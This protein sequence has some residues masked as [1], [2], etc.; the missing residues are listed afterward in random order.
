MAS[1]GSLYENADT[2]GGL[3]VAKIFSAPPHTIKILDGFNVRDIDDDHVATFAEAYRDKQPVPPILVAVGDDGSLELVDGE[4]R[5]RGAII[6]GVPLIQMVEFKG[7]REQRVAAAVR[8]NQGKQMTST[9]KARAYLRMQ[10]FGWSNARIAQESGVSEGT[11]ANHLLLAASGDEVLNMIEKDEVKPTTVI[12]LARS[13]GPHL[14]LDKLK[15]AA[16]VA[17][18]RDPAPVPGPVKAG[19]KGKTP[20]APAPQTRKQRIKMKDV[21]KATKKV[22]AESAE[23]DARNGARSLLQLLAEHLPVLEAV[24]NEQQVL[25]AKDDESLTLRMPAKNYREFVL[26]GEM[27]TEYL[28]TEKET[29]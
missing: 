20:A 6:A 13:V 18:K 29:Q 17:A 27:I 22:E 14:V 10:A 1:F 12:N 25:T 16:G 24:H 21:E 5:L 19:T 15:E 3:K 8:H 9:E 2:R 23:R 26:I 11:V 7:D 4:H 28:A